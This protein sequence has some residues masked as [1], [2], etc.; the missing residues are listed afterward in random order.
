VGR[1]SNARSAGAS[2][3]RT[4][5]TEA[6]TRSASSSGKARTTIAAPQNHAAA[7]TTGRVSGTPTIRGSR[8]AATAATASGATSSVCGQRAARPTSAGSPRRRAP[9]IAQV[10]ASPANATSRAASGKDASEARTS[11]W[12]PVT[13]GSVLAKRCAVASITTARPM[14]SASRRTICTAA[15][16]VAW[17]GSSAASRGARRAGARSFMEIRNFQNDIEAAR[18]SHQRAGGAFLP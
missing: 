11:S 6:T 9:A 7:L 17:S 5:D 12:S 10:P 1:N 18:A 14:P 4:G 15:A 3:S 13:A 2:G 16:A 8:A